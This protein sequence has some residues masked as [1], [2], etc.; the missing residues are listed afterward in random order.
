MREKN[1]RAENIY[2]QAFAV[3]ME[4]GTVFYETKADPYLPLAEEEKARWS[5]EDG[6]PAVPDYLQGLRQLFS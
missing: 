5:P 3:S 1:W 4:T 2:W 6:A